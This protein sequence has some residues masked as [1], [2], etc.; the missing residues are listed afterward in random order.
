MPS[1]HY[2]LRRQQQGLSLVELLVGLTIGLLTVTVAIG[3]LL[4]SRQ[5]A[6]AV[7]VATQLQQQAAQAFRIIGQQARQAGSVRLNLAFAKDSTQTID[8]A[9]PV[10]F[11]APTD[12]AKKTDTVSGKA[13]PASGEYKLVLAYQNYAESLVDKA[14]PASQFGDC[15][16]QAPLD[17]IIRSSFKLSKAAGAS[18][19]ELQ[20]K[21]SD[22]SRP[23]Q[24]VIANVADF[25]VRFIEQANAASG[26]P[27]M[28]YRTADTVASWPQVYAIEVCLEMEGAENLPDTET[29]YINCA[30]KSVKRGSRLRM[31]FRNT[32]QIRSQGLPS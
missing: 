15:L 17:N 7:N 26:S 32:Y 8:S 16:G 3:S 31:V 1:L 28:Q 5:V 13:A 21:G 4:I 18:S 29:Q 20:C 11:E 25:Q 12:F 6:G 23:S 27:T 10:A 19:G 22:P 9:D 24:P 30:N 14:L 2:H